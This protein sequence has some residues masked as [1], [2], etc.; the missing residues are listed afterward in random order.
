MWY[1]LFNLF[2]YSSI[3][4]CLWA[5]G[6]Y[7][8]GV[9]K[10]IKN[11]EF[12]Y[13][14]YTTISAFKS[15]SKSKGMSS[16]LD[17]ESTFSQFFYEHEDERIVYGELLIKHINDQHDQSKTP[18]EGVYPAIYYVNTQTLKVDSSLNIQLF[19]GNYDFYM[20]F[21]HQGIQYAARSTYEVK[22]HHNEIHFEIYPVLGDM[23]LSVRDVKTLASYK[24]KFL[25]GIQNPILARELKIRRLQN[26]NKPYAINTTDQSVQVYM[27]MP[28]ESG[29]L[30]SVL[31]Q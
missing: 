16:Y 4:F 26:S 24:P 31:V 7:N 12:S 10:N 11:I 25:K 28:R 3:F 13:S 1:R 18:F 15:R 20:L 8:Q 9:N 29:R 6:F 19:K 17:K 22:N 21:D 14:I 5:Y 27:K 30:N 23:V 2:C